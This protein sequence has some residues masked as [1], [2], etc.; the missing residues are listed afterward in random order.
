MQVTIETVV[1]ERD[2]AWEV[3]TPQ[4]EELWSSILPARQIVIQIES[5]QSDNLPK[6]IPAREGER[7]LYAVTWA[8]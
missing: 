5:P 1:V 3:G 8:H 7:N 2:Q 4:S 6:V